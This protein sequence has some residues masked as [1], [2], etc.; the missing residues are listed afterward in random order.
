MHR[1]Q[2]VGGETSWK[3]TTW[4]TEKEMEGRHLHVYQGNKCA[5]DGTG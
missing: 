1:V 3:M 2:K 5:V 4:K